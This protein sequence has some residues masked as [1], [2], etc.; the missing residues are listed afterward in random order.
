MLGNWV[1]VLRFKIDH[2]YNHKVYKWLDE[3]KE[4]TIETRGDGKLSAKLWNGL[5]E[6][7]GI[8]GH[9]IKDSISFEE[10]DAF[11]ERNK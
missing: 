8:E 2:S 1:R 3:R 5:M 10:I 4:S 11:L 9:R 7:L 6:S